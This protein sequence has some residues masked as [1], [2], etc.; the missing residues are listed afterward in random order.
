MNTRIPETLRH[1]NYF[2]LST[3][4]LVAAVT[5]LLATITLQHNQYVATHAVPST[6]H[7]VNQTF[8]AGN[9]EITVRNVSYTDGT[10]PFIAPENKHYVIFDI[11]IKNISL[12]PIQVL[13]SSDMYMKDTS[14]TV[15]LLSPYSLTDPFRA[16]ELAS[17]EAIHGQLSYLIAKKGEVKLF[18]DAK[19]S[20]AAQPVLIQKDTNNEKN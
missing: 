6:P 8:K 9:S 20:G 4:L 15:S 19:W 12:K 11:K 17:G 13:P 5:L 14:G 10:M 18:I 7:A 1:N 16:G 3:L 2:W